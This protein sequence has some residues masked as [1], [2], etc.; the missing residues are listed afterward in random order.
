MGYPLNHTNNHMQART[1]S[2]IRPRSNR[3]VR[4]LTDQANVHPTKEN[5]R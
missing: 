2:A 4:A 1:G 3:T 5:P